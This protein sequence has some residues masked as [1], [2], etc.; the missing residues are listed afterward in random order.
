[1]TNDHDVKKARI[2]AESDKAGALVAF[3][4]ASAVVFCL[5][6]PLVFLTCLPEGFFIEVRWPVKIMVG[7]I[8]VG[9]L[10]LGVALV[11]VCCLSR[12]KKGD[13]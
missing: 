8:V 7:S 12:W 4:L 2:Q 9:V 11:A 10:V 6:V 3:G 5:G 13:L 1:M